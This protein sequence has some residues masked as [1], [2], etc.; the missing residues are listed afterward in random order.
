MHIKKIN[1]TAKIAQ[2]QVIW[3]SSLKKACWWIWRYS[4]SRG[5][6][7]SWQKQSDRKT[8]KKSNIYIQV[9]P[10]IIY[11][12]IFLAIYIDLFRI[13]ISTQYLLFLTYDICVQ[14]GVQQYVQ[15]VYIFL[16]TN[17]LHTK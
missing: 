13:L 16:Q 4:S 17:P 9:F 12:D 6:T 2:L 15:S 11:K 14:S 10:Y 5:G 3:Y 1:K 8:D 7:A